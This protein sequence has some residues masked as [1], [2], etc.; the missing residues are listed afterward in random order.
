[1]NKNNLLKY[2][3]GYKKIS[4]PG[5]S[6]SEFDKSIGSNV[7][8]NKE[9]QKQK[10]DLVYDYL[11][12]F[13]NYTQMVWEGY[14]PYKR[15]Y[16]GFE[17][18]LQEAIAHAVTGYPNFYVDLSKLLVSKGPLTPLFEGGD[19]YLYMGPPYLD[20]GTIELLWEDNSGIGDASGYDIVTL[21]GF[22]PEYKDIEVYLEVGR[23]GDGL[24]S[25]QFP[26]SFI[27]KE[28]YIWATVS[29]NV[30]EGYYANSRYVGKV[31]LV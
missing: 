18:F 26:L 15:P 29:T 24:A 20:P 12:P 19:F 1:M 4:S 5:L 2:F 9:A 14:E 21:I 6:M 16:G 13:K 31:I 28:I 23:R 17:G 3:G 10:Y 27:G 8:F 11:Y 25:V 7:F 30:I 22:N